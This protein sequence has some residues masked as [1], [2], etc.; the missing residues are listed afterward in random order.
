MPSWELFDEQDDDYQD[1]VLGNG[2][3]VLSVEAAV[4]FGWSRWADDSVSIEHY[5]AS[6]PGK[7][8]LESFGFTAENVAARAIGLLDSVMGYDGYDGDEDDED[9]QEDLP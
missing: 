2:S 5:G 8:V 9:H 4:S 6:G 3:P 7:E 1:E